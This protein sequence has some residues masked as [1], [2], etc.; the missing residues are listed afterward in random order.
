MPGADW[1]SGTIKDDLPNMRKSLPISKAAY[2]SRET[3]VAHWL[4]SKS[5]LLELLYWFQV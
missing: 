3:P 1:W 4:D 5:A 2:Q